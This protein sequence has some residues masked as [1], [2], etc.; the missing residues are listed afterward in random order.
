MADW[1]PCVPF[2]E[3]RSGSPLTQQGW[4]TVHLPDKGSVPKAQLSQCQL[5]QVLVVQPMY[6]LQAHPRCLQGVFQ[7][8]SCC[9]H[10]RGNCSQPAAAQAGQWQLQ[11]QLQWPCKWPHEWVRGWRSLRGFI[12]WLGGSGDASKWRVKWPCQWSLEW[13][14]QWEC[15][16]QA[17]WPGELPSHL[18]VWLGLGHGCSVA[19][20]HQSEAVTMHRLLAWPLQS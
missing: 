17:H 9:L 13:R 5:T 11:W 14:F 15:Q 19:R 7:S 20:L 6:R 18:H 1:P 8:R 3:A 10:R 12:L 2:D 16:W 4:T